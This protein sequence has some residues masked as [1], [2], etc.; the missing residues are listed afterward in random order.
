MSARVQKRELSGPDKKLD[1]PGLDWLRPDR[2]AFHFLPT[3]TASGEPWRSVVAEIAH[4]YCKNHRFANWG[5]KE[6]SLRF[7]NVVLKMSSAYFCM[8]GLLGPPGR[9][10]WWGGWWEE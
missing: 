10:E 7:G 2:A 6:G 4:D 9:R 1:G 3:Y 8:Y 5:L